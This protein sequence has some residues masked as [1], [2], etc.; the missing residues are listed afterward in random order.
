MIS[1]CPEQVGDPAQHQDGSP[2]KERTTMSR[3]SKTLIIMVVASM[4]LWGCAQ[5]QNG[6]QVEKIK[7]LETKCAKLED[8]YKAVAEARDAAKKKLAALEEE[9]KILKQELEHQ[10][11]VMK[12]RDDLRNQLTA[13]TTERDALQSQ[14]EM[15]KNGLK[16]L[17]GQAEASNPPVTQPTAAATV[18]VVA[19]KS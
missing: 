18:P 12:E 19:S 10:A 16:T 9:K 2:N 4:G 8:D 15:F 3:A 13:R 14:F 5:G 17:L 1:T 7:T 11:T 6:P